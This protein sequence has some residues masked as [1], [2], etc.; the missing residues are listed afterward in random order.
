MTQRPFE[1]RS[2]PDNGGISISFENEGLKLKEPE[3]QRFPPTVPTVVQST[4]HTS[5][6][7]V[8]VPHEAVPTAVP[9]KE[10]IL[11]AKDDMNQFA[12]F[13]SNP[14]EERVRSG[15]EDP[16]KTEDNHNKMRSTTPKQT[17]IRKK[18]RLRKK[19]QKTPTR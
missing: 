17:R 16:R 4:I 6:V 10:S 7:A 18:G 5:H 13:P 3:H 1:P 11:K 14:E 12:N 8:L 9:T 15:V 19:T 2:Q